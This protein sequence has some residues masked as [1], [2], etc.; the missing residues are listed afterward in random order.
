MTGPREGSDM[1]ATNQPVPSYRDA[2]MALAEIYRR[3]EHPGAVEGS[4]EAIHALVDKV[5]SGHSVPIAEHLPWEGEGD[6][7]GA[8]VPDHLPLGDK[9]LEHR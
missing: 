3:T 7:V 5:L 4:R 2:V 1:G 6:S 9:P 8:P